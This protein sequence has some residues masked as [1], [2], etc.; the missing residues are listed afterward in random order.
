MNYVTTMTDYFVRLSNHECERIKAHES[1]KDIQYYVC[2]LVNTNG[3]SKPIKQ[4][5]FKTTNAQVFN[6]IQHELFTGMWAQYDDYI[7]LSHYII[8]GS[9]VHSTT[10]HLSN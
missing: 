10:I 4:V 3:D 6:T 5:I 2:D 1:N 8:R 9:I 7:Q